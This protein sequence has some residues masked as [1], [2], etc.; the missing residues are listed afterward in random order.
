MASSHAGE[1]NNLD[2][3][4]KQGRR[5]RI[6][7]AFRDSI[8]GGPIGK[9]RTAREE[10]IERYGPDWLGCKPA[11]FINSTFIDQ[12]KFNQHHQRQKLSNSVDP[13]TFKPV[14]TSVDYSRFVGST[15]KHPPEHVGGPATVSIVFDKAEVPVNWNASTKC[16]HRENCEA[17]TRLDEVLMYPE[18]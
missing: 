15:Q 7:Y 4:A 10:T 9:A 1:T 17:T 5:R 12:T 14:T 6:N 3:V 11:K 18:Q 2:G 16:S 8:I 13:T